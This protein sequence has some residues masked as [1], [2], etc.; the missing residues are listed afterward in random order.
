M[1]VTVSQLEEYTGN[2]EESSL[3]EV[4]ISTA[5]QIV[6]DYLGYNPEIALYE[7]F[8]SGIDDY[9]IY[10]NAQPIAQ[11]NSLVIDGVEVDVD[12]Y[13]CKGPCIIK[14]DRE[15]VFKTGI[16]NI[17]V[18]YSAGYEEI[19]G[20]IQITA[21]RIASLLQQ[22]AGGNIG[23]TGKSFA[24]NSKSFINYSDYKKYLRP[25]DGLR[26]FKV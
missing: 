16:N 2:Y 6:E 25:L 12:D 20:I 11:L 23:I 26:L 3:K 14:N 10:L 17:E 18:E 24:D 13:T 9:K 4:Y 8:F 22:E 15:R 5:E 19:P 1:M 7:D 21:L